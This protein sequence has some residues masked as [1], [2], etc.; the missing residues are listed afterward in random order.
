MRQRAALPINPSTQIDRVHLFK[1][2]SGVRDRIIGGMSG[3]E[4]DIHFDALRRSWYEH[5]R[6]NSPPAGYAVGYISTPAISIVACRI[7]GW[8]RCALVP[9]KW[10][11]ERHEPDDEIVSELELRNWSRVIALRGKAGSFGSPCQ[12]EFDG[13]GKFRF[14]SGAADKATWHTLL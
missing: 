3:D 14:L 11:I 10:A 8:A 4:R 1:I 7:A 12:M 13:Q 5:R 6:A 9:G 2:E